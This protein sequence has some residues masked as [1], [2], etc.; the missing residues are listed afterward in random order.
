M[1][2]TSNDFGIFLNTL[3]TETI[4]NYYYYYSYSQEGGEG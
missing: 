2:D 4:T 1:M 3:K